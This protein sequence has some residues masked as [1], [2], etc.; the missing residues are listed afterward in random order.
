MKLTVA[1]FMMC[2]AWHMASADTEKVLFKNDFENVKTGSVPEDFLVLDGGFA[3]QEGEGGKF[4]ELP[5]APLETFGLVF[6]PTETH[7][8]CV[9]ARIY[10]TNKGRRAPAFA[11]GLNGYAGY[12]LRVSAAKKLVELCRADE[13]KASVPFEWTSGQWTH[14]ELQLQKKNGQWLVTGKVWGAGA[15]APRNPTIT[16]VDSEEPP[17]GRPSIWGLPYSGTPIRFDDLKVTAAK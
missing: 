6:G 5:G 4:L 15:E 12:K 1:V 2:I 8:L 11:V 9:S 3:V 7:G 13:V 10:G 14:L 17:P 16:F